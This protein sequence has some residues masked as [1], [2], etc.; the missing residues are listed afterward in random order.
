MSGYVPS[1]SFFDCL[2]NREFP[3]TITIRAADSRDYL[4]EPDVFHDLAGHVPMHTDRAFSNAL[5]RI[6]EV[7]HTAA[8]MARD[9]SRNEAR[10]HRLES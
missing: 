10:L 3:T 5:V 9:S 8:L 7:A 2:R 6:G 4:P 1:F